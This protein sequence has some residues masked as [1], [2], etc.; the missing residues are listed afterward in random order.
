MCITKMF[1][2]LVLLVLVKGEIVN[3]SDTNDC[4]MWQI[5]LIRKSGESDVPI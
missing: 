3:R 1:R 5:I 2:D 4:I